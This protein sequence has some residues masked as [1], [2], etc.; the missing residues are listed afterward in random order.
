MQK[1]DIPANESHR[2]AVLCELQILDTPPEERFDRFTRIARTV[3]EVPMALISLVD[4]NRQWFKSRQGLDVSETPREISF[5]GH[6]ILNEHIMCIRDAKADERFKD[7]PLVTGS[8]N[9]RFYAGAPLMAVDGSRLGT[10][11]V[12]D[13]RP[14]QPS[15][16]QLGILED[17]ARCVS[18]EMNQEQLRKA[19]SD[20]SEQVRYTENILDSVADGIITVDSEGSIQSF[21]PA[22]ERIFGHDAASIIGEDFSTLMIRQHAGELRQ[23]LRTHLAGGEVERH[24]IK[25]EVEAR[26][27]D[28]S[29]FPVS[30]AIGQMDIGGTPMFN[31]VF[32]NIAARK[33]LEQMKDEFISTVSHE[34]RTPL[35]SIL[36]SIGLI[37]GGA[38]GTVSKEM[39]SMLEVAY[40]SCERLV[41]LINDMLDLERMKSGH[42][43]LEQVETD[44]Q[45]LAAQAVAELEGYCQRYNVGVHLSSPGSP[46][47]VLGD[48]D[49]LLRVITNM[50]ANAVKF[51]PPEGEVEIVLDESNGVLRLAVSDRGPGIPESFKEEVFT[52]FSQADNSDSRAKSGTGLG[53][54]IAKAI[55]EEHDGLIGF[56]ERTKGGTTFYFELPACGADNKATSH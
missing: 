8:P 2:L 56:T 31:A 39:A 38:V 50:V 30:L 52:R 54:S 22:A 21:N 15:R 17:L 44:L 3:F 32:R 11:C 16:I 10:L 12:L 9:I 5:C 33:K 40:K 37:K 47:I 25:R 19:L 35:T 53:M 36:G 7:N 48:P 27:A 1:P 20:L 23:A 26:R 34:M 43:V 18:N 14:Q 41:G 4:A 6:A 42:V 28:G 51:S 29:R 49:Q 24:E 45:A 55:I 13:T 46:A